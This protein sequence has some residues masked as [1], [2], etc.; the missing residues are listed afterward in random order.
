LQ[1]G[2]LSAGSRRRLSVQSPFPFSEVIVSVLR[3]I[4]RHAAAA[5]L[6]L[7]PAAM[8]AQGP[9]STG[10]V[11]NGTNDLV[12]DLSVNGGSFFDAFLVTSRPGAWEAN[13]PGNYL[14][15]GAT[16]TGSIQGGTSDGA[17]NFAYTFQTTFLGGAVSG[18]TFRCAVDNGLRAIMLNGVAQAASCGTFLFGGL[19]SLSGFNAGLNTLQFIV[20]G[21][22]TTDGLLVDFDQVTTTPE[23][24]SL[25][26]LA[27]GLLGVGVVVRRRR[28][29]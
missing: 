22:G 21:D 10:V 18:V 25:A 7:A 9:V 4:G 8:S 15:I 20:V 27:T 24:A 26:L 14:W 3:T 5:L 13:S 17:P 23:P 11:N 12:W 6:L 2:P 28:T 1:A 29:A 16:P 19:Q